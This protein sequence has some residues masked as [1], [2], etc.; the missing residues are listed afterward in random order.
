[1]AVTIGLA[2]AEDF[3][4]D[5]V[6]QSAAAAAGVDTSAVVVEVQG[7]DVRLSLFFDSAASKEDIQQTVALASGV[8]VS[9]VSVSEVAG[10]R[11]LNTGGFMSTYDLT[12]QVGDLQEAAVVQRAAVDEAVLNASLHIVRSGTWLAPVVATIPTVEVHV[13]ITGEENVAEALA[14]DNCARLQAVLAVALGVPITVEAKVT[15]STSE[16]PPLV[17]EE[18]QS[19]ASA[20]GAIIV[21]LVLCAVVLLALVVGLVLRLFFGESGR[22]SMVPAAAP[23]WEPGQK[24]LATDDGILVAV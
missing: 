12:I 23:A 9:S 18:A 2:D 19:T 10:A 22:D 13:V 24:V 8:A 1:M 16:P 17:S 14:G 5:S 3:D 15:A 20:L 11:R 6:K 4:I 7:A 21:V